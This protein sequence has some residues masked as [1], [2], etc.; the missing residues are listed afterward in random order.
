[1]TFFFFFERENVQCTV[2]PN[3]LETSI[4]PTP[5]SVGGCKREIQKVL[6]YAKCDISIYSP[7]VS[8]C[9]KAA[10]MP[11]M[12]HLTGRGEEEEVSSLEQSRTTNHDELVGKLLLLSRIV[13][14]V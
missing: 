3:C 8:V 4:G 10:L 14:V 6:T 12:A 7:S 13:R 9:Q 5:V 1:M 2:Y 11:V